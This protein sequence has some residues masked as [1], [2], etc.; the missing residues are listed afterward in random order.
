MGTWVKSSYCS[1][2]SHWV[3]NSRELARGGGDVEEW[4]W[5]KS[6]IPLIKTFWQKW[7]L[8]SGRK[9]EIKG[10]LKPDR[11]S[12]YLLVVL[13][14]GHSTTI[15]FHHLGYKPKMQASESPSYANNKIAK[16]FPDASFKKLTS[17]PDHP[18]YR[19]KAFE[20][21]NSILQKGH[22]GFPGARAFGVDVAFDRNVSIVMRDGI[23]LHADA[24]RP[25]TSD[26]SPVP[27][28]I[29]WSAYGKTGTG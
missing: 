11:R 22:V 6:L 28:I 27:V 12:L 8:I 19:Y 18:L 13:A 26:T 17:P 3:V 4:K 23:T 2:N 15:P 21:S 16:Q 25:V 7:K 14:N 20:K 5:D 24:F 29:P 10:N 9:F 1:G